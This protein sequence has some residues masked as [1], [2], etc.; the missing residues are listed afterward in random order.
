MYDPTQVREDLK[1]NARPI[2]MLTKFVE[3]G[4][5]IRPYNGSWIQHPIVREGADFVPVVRQPDAILQNMT[6]KVN[7]AT[8]TT[9]TLTI[10]NAGSASIN[11]QTPITFYDG[12]MNGYDI[13]SGAT[14]IN[15][16][17]DTIIGVDI[18]PDEKVTRT[19]T[20]TGTNYTDHLIWARIMDKNGNFPASGYD[21]CDLS[22]NVFSGIDCPSLLY[23]V[24]ASPDTVLC[25]E[26]DPVLLTAVPTNTPTTP[27]YQWYRNDVAIPGANSSTHQ[28]TSTGEYKCYVT[29]NICRGFSVN[30]VTLTREHPVAV[31]D[32]TTVLAGIPTKINVLMNDTLS[33][34][35]NTLPEIVSGA[36]PSHGTATVDPDGSISYLASDITY[37]GYD[38]LTYLIDNSTAKVYL[39]VRPLPDNI[40]EAECFIPIP[41]IE[42]S[43]NEN[44]TYSPGNSAPQAFT[45]YTTPL[46]GDLDDDGIPEIIVY[47]Y[48]NGSEPRTVNRVYV[49][50]GND[51]AH[52][53]SFQIPETSYMHPMGALAKV[54][55]NGVLTPILVFQATDG[56][57]YA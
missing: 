27:A 34:Y 57:L 22:N 54:E 1:I 21:D 8:Q 42:W 55:I 56:Y 35:C 9:V 2:S 36:G 28:A 41:S 40:S 14:K 38:T 43:I 50:W 39:T 18:F 17:S 23:T 53:R 11:A 48:Y 12:G 29:D 13:S 45:A 24:T 44:F 47:N 15:N 20:L 16:V 32:F 5:T 33:N 4:D 31:N 6:V 52:P 26:D 49:F 37:E 10:Y 30:T 3:N 51:R 46:V 19:Y 7:S 25:G